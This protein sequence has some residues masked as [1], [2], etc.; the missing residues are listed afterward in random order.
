M[1][2]S[3]EDKVKEIRATL[4]SMGITSKQVS[5]SGKSALYD[6]VIVAKIKDLTVN[7][8]Q[9]EEVLNQYHEVEYCE[10]SGEIL[11][12][13]NTYTRTEYDTKSLGV[14]KDEMLPLATKII[15]DN[16]TLEAGSGV[17]IY[18]DDEKEIVYFNT[19]SHDGLGLI[20]L[21]GSIEY[22]DG[23]KYF[24]KDLCRYA[25]YNENVVAEALAVFKYQYG[26]KIA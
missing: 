5:I 26:T 20:I 8:K 23:S 6:S 12:G 9:I 16:K 15:Q 2:K 17:A 13:G 1:F 14:A 18:K 4:K 21:K 7:R 25:A 22:E 19:L 10:Y 24:D 11:N 3:R